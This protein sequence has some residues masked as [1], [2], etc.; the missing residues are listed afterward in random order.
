MDTRRNSEGNHPT[1]FLLFP[2]P[3]FSDH[4]VLNSNTSGEKE[5]PTSGLR[6]REYG[7]ESRSTS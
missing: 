6:L 7:A 4:G 5:A 2:R 1:L 3:V